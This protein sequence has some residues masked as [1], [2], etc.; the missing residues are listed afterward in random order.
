MRTFKLYFISYLQNLVTYAKH[1]VSKKTAVSYWHCIYDE[2]DKMA[3][4][5]MENMTCI[6]KINIS[7][8]KKSYKKCLLIFSCKG[9]RDNVL[10]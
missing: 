7:G 2:S 10:T 4:K 6:A 5:S 3:L 8:L 9:E 1:Y